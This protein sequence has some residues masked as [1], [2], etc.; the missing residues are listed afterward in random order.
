VW[1][2]A[3]PAASSDLKEPPRL[4]QMCPKLDSFRTRLSDIAW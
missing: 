4:S 3:V 2:A 1:K